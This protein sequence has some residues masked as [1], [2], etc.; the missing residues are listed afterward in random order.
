MPYSQLTRSRLI[1]CRSP[2]APRWV[3]FTLDTQERIGA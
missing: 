1:H 2:R 3:R